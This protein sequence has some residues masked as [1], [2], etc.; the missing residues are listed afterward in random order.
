MTYEDLDKY[1]SI[2]QVFNEWKATIIL[3]ETMKN[4]GHWTLLLKHSNNILEFFDPYGL[5]VD[6]E[7]NFNNNFYVRT[8]NNIQVPHLSYLINKSGYELITNKKK[9]QQFLEHINTCGRWCSGRVI[10]RDVPLIE[11][12]KLFTNNINHTPDFWI[13]AYTYLL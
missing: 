4:F 11:F 5:N 6:E 10:L 7:L 12:Q 13:S 1:E 8:H 3:Y 2:E 9:L